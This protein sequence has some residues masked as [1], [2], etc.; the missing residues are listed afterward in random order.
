[1]ARN[2]ALDH[3]RGE[4]VIFLDADD[5]W[6]DNHMLSDLYQQIRTDQADLL[7]FGVR[8]LGA[9]GEVLFTDVDRLSTRFDLATRFDWKISYATW[10]HLI[11]RKL[12]EKNQLRFE[13]GLSMGEDALFNT[14]LYCHARRLSLSTRVC[15]DYRY[16]PASANHA[17][18]SAHQ[19]NCTIWWFELAIEVI[20]QSPAYTRRPDLL[21][22]LCL[23]R[24]NNLSRR[25]GHLALQNLDENQL[26]DFV[27]RWAKCLAEL[28]NVERL[29]ES[30]QQLLA[31]L[32]QQDVAAFKDFFKST[33]EQKRRVT[34]NR[35]QAVQL[36]RLLLGQQDEQVTVNLGGGQSLS[37]A[38][39][40]AHDLARQ[41]LNTE[42]EQFIL[43][44]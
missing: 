29:P 30:Q 13:P 12:I 11:R 17:R 34:L 18:W 38:K 28:E 36:G 26:E 2:L 8:K 41:L 1:V 3:A 33:P 9:N 35:Q 22:D 44:L 42:H 21:R 16:N 27:C 40:K 37:L 6:T 4:Y 5:Y 23:E 24:L 10:A 43:E 32:G 39:S 19:L 31:V 14:G 7:R 20:K 25:L 15:Y